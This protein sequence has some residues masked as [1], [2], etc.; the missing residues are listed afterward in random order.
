MIFIKREV[1]RGWL[2]T[3][4]HSGENPNMYFQAR[5]IDNILASS[6]P[7]LREPHSHPEYPND[8]EHVQKEGMVSR[9]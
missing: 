2:D 5:D 7:H 4:F 1:E 6:C 3:N 9:Y 8:N